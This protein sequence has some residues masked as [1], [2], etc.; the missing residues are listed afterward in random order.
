MGLIMD[1]LKR[2][3]WLIVVFIAAGLLPYQLR[4]CAGVEARWKAV[5]V[6]D[7][8]SIILEKAGRLY[9]VR[10]A[11][12][13]APE[14]GWKDRP[15]Q[16]FAVESK[17]HLEKLVECESLDVKVIDR[18]R[19]GR[20]LVVIFCDG[21]NINLKMVEDGMAE[22][23]RGRPSLDISIYRLAEEEARRK[24]LGIWSQ[25]YYISPRIWRRMH[26]RR[27]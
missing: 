22:Y 13:D 21:D 5:R 15:A 23:Y 27:W 7:G 9:E 8:D 3:R 16:P 6:I 18:D 24:A 1:I 17:E 25:K 19:Y 10:L 2:C 26:P 20:L 14:L 11:G 12:I 4:H